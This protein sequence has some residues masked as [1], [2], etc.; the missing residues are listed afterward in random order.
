M[1]DYD[2]IAEIGRLR[3]RVVELERERDTAHNDAIQTAANTA[4]TCQGSYRVDGETIE[5]APSKDQIAA[6]ILKL[7]R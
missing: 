3:A 1:S 4:S 7:F 2:R 5:C 6:A